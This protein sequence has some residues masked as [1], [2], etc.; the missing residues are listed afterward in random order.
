MRCHNRTV[1]VQTSIIPRQNS[2]GKKRYRFVVITMPIC[3]S[4][5]LCRSAQNIAHCV[6]C[7]IF[8]ANPVWEDL[9][10]KQSAFAQ[11]HPWWIATRFSDDRD[12]IAIEELRL[13]DGHRR[14]R[15]WF[16]SDHAKGRTQTIIPW[17]WGPRVVVEEAVP[18]SC[19]SGQDDIRRFGS[20]VR[21]RIR[22]V[23]GGRAA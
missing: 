1:R 13:V 10:K 22:N 17:S 6:P 4:I 5:C 12:G 23:A 15:R 9:S 21:L 2:D 20:P 8:S 14:S 7:F 3:P 16:L 19:P 11:V 18:A